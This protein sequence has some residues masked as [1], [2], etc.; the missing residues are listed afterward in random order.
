MITSNA[1]IAGGEMGA[2][3]RDFDWSASPIGPMASWPASLQITL[4]NMLSS[5]LPTCLLWG[6]H[7]TSFYNDAFRTQVNKTN[8]PAETLGLPARQSWPEIWQTIEPRIFHIMEKREGTRD[9]DVLIPAS[10][11][12]TSERMFWTIAC[13]PVSDESK[14]VAGILITAIDTTSNV[15]TRE[16]L[17]E[18]ASQLEAV[19]DAAD[20]G[21]WDDDLVTGQAIYN[22]RLKQ[23]FGYDKN[24][25]LVLQDFLDRMTPADRRR[26]TS[27]IELSR[28]DEEKAE[29][30]IEYTITIP[31][32]SLQ[33]EVRAKGK[34]IFNSQKIPVRF[35]GTLQ[36]VT[37]KNRTYKAIESNLRHM[38][39]LFEN[40]P[41]AIATISADDELRFLG[42]NRFYGKLVGRTP[43]E[44][45]GKPL[46]E[47]LPELQGQGF[48]LLLKRVIAEG[49]GHTAYEIPV[50]LA[51]QDALETVYVNFS[52]VPQFD[53][54]R[55]VIGVLVTANDV[56]Y[57]VVA[58]KAI[59]EKEAL[60]RSLIQAAPFPIGV[61]IGENMRIEYANPAIIQVYGKGPDV[62]G[63]G[64]LELLPEL[65]KQ[66]IGQQLLDVYHTG[67]PFLSNTSRVDIDVEGSI[68][69]YYFKYSFIP[70]FDSHG[71]VYGVL[72]TGVDVTEVEVA[73]QRAIEAESNLRS[74]VE[75][76]GLAN[77]SINLHDGILQMSDRLKDWI[78]ARESVLP[79][80]DFFAYLPPAARPYIS[81]AYQSAIQPD[82]STAFDIE[83]ALIHAV[84]GHSRFI[85]VRGQIV[86]DP[87]GLPARL[88]G[89]MQD[90]TKQRAIQWEL[91]R[92]VAE[93][94]EEL[95]QLNAALHNANTELERK[96]TELKQ[97]NDELSQYAYVTS[98]DL[99]EPLR[100][101]RI[102]ISW[103]KEK[104]SLPPES[105][106]LLEKI[107][108]SS[109]R[110]MQLVRDL[111][112]FSRLL[113][114]NMPMQPVHL[115][116]IVTSVL[117][118]F[119]LAIE[120]K[121]AT[122]QVST[123]PV[124]QAVAL[125]MNQLFYNLISNALKFTAPD[126]QPLITI[127]VRTL[128]ASEIA[129]LIS[130]PTHPV[131]YEITFK[132]NGIGF[133]PEYA[134]YIFELFRQL[135]NHNRYPGSGIGLS[136][137]R[138]IASNHGGY[139]YATSVYG[140]GSTFHVLLP[141][142]DPTS[143]ATPA[144]MANKPDV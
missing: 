7:L 103:L 113:G 62:I 23:F 67:K 63:R 60:F 28:T 88:T 81:N 31:G 108:N 142:S 102:Y 25:N 76:A 43:S 70:L 18:K 136:L 120:E 128:S 143:P 141:T 140:Q 100:K 10:D 118:D 29:F 14:E 110:M 96:N 36:D 57:Q 138:R 48:D 111:L 134:E 91:Q 52:Y 39:D 124:I 85:H 37:K 3:I 5:P 59:E 75:L 133:E 27:A 121:K 49:I 93:R 112:S 40:A 45:V 109:T 123:L 122:V 77:W 26:M 38:Q 42:A 106:Q 131:F 22:D 80:N 137:C 126:R 68:R 116:Q 53:H 125:H 72:N 4:A 114:S 2:R 64:Y 61:Y 46:L 44:V 99:Q 47:A 82:N 107:N 65:T 101:I 98:H 79:L 89:T 16:M 144:Q 32:S 1:L 15:K 94:T 83:H 78:G 97:S 19:I 127:S 30:D 6:P 132:D 115:D 66:G 73:R 130:Q 20:L 17:K 12:G 92:Q 51:R 86:P 9:E 54:D 58:R 104:Y 74:A 41:V 105:A 50:R 34:T 90:I 11:V 69:S 55:R 8:K 33:R 84:T 95:A 135:H 139:I 56:S 129:H 71:N 117:E 13:S 21:T 87:S 119:E 35:T 24:A